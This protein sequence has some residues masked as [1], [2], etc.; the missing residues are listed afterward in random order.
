MSFGLSPG[1]NTFSVQ[2]QKK[3]DIL[4]ISN[5]KNIHRGFIL[6]FHRRTIFPSVHSFSQQISIGYSECVRNYFTSMGG[7][8][9]W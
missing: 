9:D 2:M 5:W 3:G 8:V 4:E 7:G 1:F 6:L